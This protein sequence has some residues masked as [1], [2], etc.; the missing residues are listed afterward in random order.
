VEV[1]IL[2]EGSSGFLGLGAKPAR[3]KITEKRWGEP[4]SPAPAGSGGPPADRSKPRPAPRAQRAAP[5]R[6]EPRP[7]AAP[8]VAAHAAGRAEERSRERSAAAPPA[9]GLPQER[10]AREPRLEK[11][12]CEDPKAACE[13]ARGL[14]QELLRLMQFQEVSIEV[15]WDAEQERVKLSLSGTDADRLVGPDGKALESLQFL[16]TLILNRRINAQVAVQVDVAGYW[17]KREKDILSQVERGIAEVKRSGKPFRLEPM[18]AL[19]RR[20]VHRHFASHPDILTASEGEGAWRKI[21][22]RPRQ[23]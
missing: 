10:P 22:L 8:A 16:L 18:D 4:S 19:M 6:R 2:Q 15:S 14:I 23:G 11:T 20:L 3:V 5:A 12:K 17:A 21:V 7:A 13:Q 9:A 1:Q